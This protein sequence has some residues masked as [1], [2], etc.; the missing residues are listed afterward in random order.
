MKIGAK[1]DVILVQLVG[2]GCLLAAPFWGVNLFYGDPHRLP[3]SEFLVI[4]GLVFVAV[5]A[6]VYLSGNNNHLRQVMLVTLL[7]RLMACS[8]SLYM[9]FVIFE[10]EADSMHY[11]T[12]GRYVSEIFE[13]TGELRFYQPLWGGSF[14]GNVNGVL[15]ILF[16][17][18]MTMGTVFYSLLA[19]WG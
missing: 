10:T 15:F 6:C 19:F 5:S 7:C 17:G 14:V 11:V 12:M 3:S 18:S 2:I 4:P 9:A 13:A 1:R 8:L 16:G